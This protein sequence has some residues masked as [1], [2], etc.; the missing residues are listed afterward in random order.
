ME[1]YEQ[2]LDKIKNNKF[3]VYGAGGHGQKLV[4][5]I[6]QMGYA[7]NFAGFAVTESQ[8]K[9]IDGVK[10][11]KNIDRNQ[12]VIIA[13]HDQNAMQMEA[14]LK[15]LGFTQYV[16]VYPYLIDFCCGTSYLKNQTVYVED[17][18]QD[19]L[20]GH[21][22]YSAYPIVVYLAIDHIMGG[23]NAGKS[24]YLKLIGK[25]AKE[26]TAYQRWD[27]LVKR[28]KNYST[29][30]LPEP[31]AVKINPVQRYVLDGYHRIILSKYFGIT[32]ILAD[33]Y[34]TDFEKYRD[35]FWGG[36]NLINLFTKEEADFIL[37]TGR[38]LTEA[39]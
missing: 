29:D 39:G 24:L 31:F 35:M 34:D 11:I 27:A 22:F 15:S 16:S 28:A 23:N 14:V 5:A 2:I 12:F 21:C 33:Y 18:F 3:V 38:R 32:A 20:R 26:K 4:R 30:G 8:A 9:D 1:T 17:I 7:D 36:D 10:E 6:T 37:E 13:A 25:Y 19:C